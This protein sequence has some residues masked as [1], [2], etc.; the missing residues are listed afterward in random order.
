VL[1]VA[2]GK[3]DRQAKIKDISVPVQNEGTKVK[4]KVDRDE[5]SIKNGR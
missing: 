4:Y 3:V 1:R 5:R 2:T